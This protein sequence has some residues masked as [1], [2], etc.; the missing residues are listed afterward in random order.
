[1][2]PKGQFVP[3]TFGGC[4]FPV[5]AIERLS[6]SCIISRRYSKDLNVRRGRVLLHLL[7]HFPSPDQK[8]GKSDI[9]WSFNQVF[10]WNFLEL[11]WLWLS[12][13]TLF[14][15]RQRGQHVE[16]VRMV[17]TKLQK[18]QQQFE[19]NAFSFTTP[20]PPSYFRQHQEL[21]NEVKC[22]AKNSQI[23]QIRKRWRGDSNSWRACGKL[24]DSGVNHRKAVM[25]FLLGVKR[26]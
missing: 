24:I 4:V 10:Y 9:F 22:Q 13:E 3:S 21:E 20:L 1:M 17:K 14:L 16:E 12:V 5:C 7:Q 11:L 2:S 18:F 19:K 8:K 25:E 15:T 23:H 6:W 26:R